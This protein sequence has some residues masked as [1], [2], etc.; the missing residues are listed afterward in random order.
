MQAPATCGKIVPMDKKSLLRQELIK[1][2]TAI[3]DSEQAAKNSAIRHR[4]LDEV[5]WVNVS[6]LHIYSSREDWCE[7]DTHEL[8]DNLRQLYPD[9]KIDIADQQG[10][11]LPQSTYEYDII[12]VPV[13]GFDSHNNRIGMGMGWY[14]RFLQ[15]Q[16]AALK[17]GLAYKEL[18]VDEMPT[19]PHD[20][21]LNDII[22]A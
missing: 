13:L 19:E 22:A 8:T 1:R 12:I 3:S 9:L 17:L 20:V 14:D 5:D 11:E 21:A 2:R 10:S 6:R 15:L 4:L 16:P 7:V 18:E